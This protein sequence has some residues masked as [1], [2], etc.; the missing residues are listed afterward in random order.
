MGAEAGDGEVALEL[1]AVVVERPAH[2]EAGG[3]FGGDLH[4]QQPIRIRERGRNPLL[5]PGRGGGVGELLLY[6]E[7]GAKVVEF[8]AGN[9]SIV[10]YHYRLWVVSSDPARAHMLPS[11]HHTLPDQR[12]A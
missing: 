2:A 6:N 4:F 7:C 3:A 8:R 1:L 11:P 10:L 5:P 12:G 9:V